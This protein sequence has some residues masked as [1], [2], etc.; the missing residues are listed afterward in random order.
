MVAI[1]VSPELP[2]APVATAMAIP[3]AGFRRGAAGLGPAAERRTARAGFLVSR[4]MSPQGSGDESRQPA[5]AAFPGQIQIKP[6]AV[7]GGSA[8]REAPTV[9]LGIHIP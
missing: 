2:A 3:G 7:A 8:G 9:A 4:G 5:V 1:V 6:E